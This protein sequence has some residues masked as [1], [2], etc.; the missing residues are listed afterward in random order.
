MREQLLKAQRYQQR[1]QACEENEEI[2]E[3]EFDYKCE[4][5]LPLLERKIQ[6]HFHAHRADDIFTAL[7]IAKEFNLDA[8]IIHTT[9]GHLITKELLAEQAKVLSG[10]FLCDRS[11]PELKNQTPRSPGLMANAGLVPAIITDHPV[12]PTQYLPLCAALAVREGMTEED[13]LR[14]ITIVPAQILRLENR[15]GSL[16]VGKD[17]DLVVWDRNPL[18]LFAKAKFV[19][20]DGHRVH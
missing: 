3:P 1:L 14:A 16:R 11:K 20:I 7:R 15:V 18:D 2:D 9:E 12:V 10:P 19:M 13:A 8:V 4:A 5:L 6:A 17:A